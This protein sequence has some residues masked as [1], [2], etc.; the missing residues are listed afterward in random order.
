MVLLVKLNL[1]MVVLKLKFSFET[2]FL[3]ITRKSKRWIGRK[4]EG[5]ERV[6][7]KRGEKGGRE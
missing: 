6:R 4:R 1:I 7:K 2:F 3:G 5:R